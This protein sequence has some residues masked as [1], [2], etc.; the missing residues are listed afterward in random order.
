LALGSP[1]KCL[2]LLA[3]QREVSKASACMATKLSKLWPYKVIQKLCTASACKIIQ[4]MFFEET[5]NSNC[6]T[7]LILT[8]FFRELTE[9]KM[10][11]YF[12]QDNAMAHIANF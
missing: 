11:S 6:Y 8:P 9:E 7:Q 4:P 1:K 5:I 2:R 12:M 10:Y 3:L